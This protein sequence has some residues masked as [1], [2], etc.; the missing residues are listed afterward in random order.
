ML[1]LIRTLRRLHSLL[2]LFIEKLRNC[3]MMAWRS[4]RKWSTPI[5]MFV[6]SEWSRFI[7]RVLVP[8]WCYLHEKC[9]SSNE[10]SLKR[11]V[12]FV[13]G[14]SPW[15]AQRGGGI[16]CSHP[17]RWN[18]LQLETEQRSYSCWLPRKEDLRFL[19]A[20]RNSI[21]YLNVTGCLLSSSFLPNSILLFTKFF[22][23]L[24]APLT[25]LKNSFQPINLC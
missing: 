3:W 7:P 17:S 18:S 9:S 2:G 8:W 19:I 25:L 10:C 23:H 15:C 24:F 14:L 4:M 13:G 22:Q 12:S 6:G 16:G 1:L 11:S 20:Y 21:I 5:L